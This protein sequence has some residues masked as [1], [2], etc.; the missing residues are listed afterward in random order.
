MAALSTQSAST[1]TR[2]ARA[3]LGNILDELQVVLRTGDDAAV[4]AHGSL[5]GSSVEISPARSQDEDE[6]EDEDDGDALGDLGRLER[7]LEINERDAHGSE[8]KERPRRCITSRIA[9]NGLCDHGKAR[10]TAHERALPIVE[11]GVATA[12]A[13]KWPPAGEPRD[14]VRRQATAKALE[15]YEARSRS[16]S[17]RTAPTAEVAKT[18]T[19]SGARTATGDQAKKRDMLERALPIWVRTYRSQQQG[20]GHHAV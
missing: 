17:G 8:S 10:D 13:S 20:S 19:T 4:D 1:S 16:L 14:R 9:Y 12:A 15:L 18:L 2:R 3:R 11:T 6:D 7:A 5:A